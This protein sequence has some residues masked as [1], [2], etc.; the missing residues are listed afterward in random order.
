MYIFKKAH[1]KK[2]VILPYEEYER[3]I[4]LSITKENLEKGLFNKFVG[5]LNKEFKTDDIKYQEIVK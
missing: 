5:I 3:L 4:K 1:Q 2:A